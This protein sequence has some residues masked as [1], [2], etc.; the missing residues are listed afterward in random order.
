[1]QG[2]TVMRQ[3]S[4]ETLVTEEPY[5]LIAHV[6]VCG[7][8][9]WVT[10]GSTRRRC[11]RTLIASGSEDLQVEHPVCGGYAPAFHLHP[12]LP[13]MLGAPLIRDQVVQVGQ[14]REKRL[15]AAP[16][17]MKAFHGEQF[18]LES[19]M[20][21]I[22]HRARYR[23]L[24]VCEHR[25]PPRLLVLHPAPHTFPVGRPSHGGDVVSEVA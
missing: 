12:T 17:V 7:G 21:L 20:G 5:A 18:P 22:E 24:G 4:A 11:R 19:V 10:T 14:P 1:M 6:R 13:G 15:L 2:S 3:S 23:H 25:I 9:G 8:A 16:W